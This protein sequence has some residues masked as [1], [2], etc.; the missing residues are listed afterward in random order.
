[1]KELQN[2]KSELQI[3]LTSNGNGSVYN[4]SERHLRFYLLEYY[5]DKVGRSCAVLKYN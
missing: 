4:P 1:M 5:W 3:I 2:A